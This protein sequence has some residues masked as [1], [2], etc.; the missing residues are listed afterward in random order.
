MANKRIQDL[1]QTTNLTN[2]D[3]LPLDTTKKTFAI[4]LKSL[5]EWLKRTFQTTANMVNYVKKTGDTMTGTLTNNGAFVSQFDCLNYIARSK[6][7]VKGTT[8]A[9]NKFVGY[10]WQDKNGA[11]LAYLGVT[12]QANGIKRL[13]LQKIDSNLT[14]FLINFKSIFTDTVIAQLNGNTRYR[15]IC[16]GYTKGT[17]PTVPQFGGV[18]TY[19]KNNVEIA[20]IYSAIDTNN[21]VTSALWVKQPTAAGTD[22]KAISIYCDKNGVFHTSCSVQSA[23]PNSIVTTIAHGTNYM[24]FGNGLQIC[25]GTSAVGQTI[26]L[27]QPFKDA[28]YKITFCQTN[29]DEHDIN[30]VVRDKDKTTTSFRF[31][32]G[33]TGDWI[34]LGYWY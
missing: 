16:Q 5:V 27:P 26:T 31:S 22:A 4:T 1:E 24:R 14:E 9:D 15:C 23:E 33:Y 8:P 18:S 30:Q 28:N 20:T 17:A 6:T 2:D 21:A 10:D 13:E 25:W 32:R 29:V 19:D 3:L 34:A 12:Y 7:L 11:R